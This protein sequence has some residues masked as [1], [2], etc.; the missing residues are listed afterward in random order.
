MTLAL[1][2]GHYGSPLLRGAKHW[3]FLL[4]NFDGT[5]IAYQISG[6][7]NDYYLKDPVLVVPNRVQSY[8]G[9]VNV[10]QISVERVKD[11]DDV[12]KSVPVIRGSLQWNCQDWIIDALTM[13]RYNGFRV[14]ALTKEA[15]TLRLST[16]VA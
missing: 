8:M 16:V 15:L 11:F 2:I 6:S 14:E 10:G 5:A 12:L 9:R 13:L 1:D 3:S 4:M 7:T